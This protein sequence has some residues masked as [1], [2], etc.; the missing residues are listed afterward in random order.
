M[1]LP[2]ECCLMMCDAV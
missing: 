2:E 1:L